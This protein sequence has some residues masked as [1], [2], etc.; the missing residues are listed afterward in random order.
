L[1][2]GLKTDRVKFEGDTRIFPAVVMASQ[3]VMVSKRNDNKQ[4]EQRYHL[5]HNRTA[6]EAF[7]GSL[8][9]EELKNQLPQIEICAQTAYL[10]NPL[11]K[12]LLGKKN[13]QH[14]DF[15]NQQFNFKNVYWTKEENKL[16]G[17]TYNSENTK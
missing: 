12:D 14:F 7:D 16:K 1:Y 17:I 13:A 2:L 3:S 9:M 15:K 5:I 11:I 4:Y 10:V 6:A 8:L